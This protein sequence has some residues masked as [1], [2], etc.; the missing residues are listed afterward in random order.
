M[1]TWTYRK[2]ISGEARNISEAGT[3]YK[4]Q[5]LGVPVSGTPVVYLGACQTVWRRQDAAGLIYLEILAVRVRKNLY[6]L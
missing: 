3:P 2:A 1:S 6:I 4:K 5:A